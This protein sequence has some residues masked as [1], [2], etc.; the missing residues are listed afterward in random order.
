MGGYCPV[1]IRERGIWAQGRSRFHTRY[2]DKIYLFA[3]AEQRDAFLKNPAEYLPVFSGDCIV[4]YVQSQQRIAGKVFHPAQYEGRLFLFA[5]D[6][7]LEAFRADP[8]AYADAD[9]AAEGFCVVTQIDHGEVAAGLPEHIA[10]YHGQRYLFVT[11]E[12]KE[13]FL[14]DSERYAQQRI[15]SPASGQLQTPQL[16]TPLS[17]GTAEDGS[18]RADQ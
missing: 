10:L 3:G 9:L 5:G 13:Q 16:Q 11:D 2:E 4:S 6:E 8:S 15:S 12:R 14:A 18:D 17:T 7:Q 1:S